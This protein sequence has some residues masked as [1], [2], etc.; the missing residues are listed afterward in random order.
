[1]ILKIRLNDDFEKVAGILAKNGYAV[2]RVKVK[3]NKKSAEPGIEITGSGE[4]EEVED[5]E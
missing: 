3:G 4:L 2:R 1:M 5:E